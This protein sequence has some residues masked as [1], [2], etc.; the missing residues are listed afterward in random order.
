VSIPEALVAV[1]AAAGLALL[2]VMSRSRKALMA[3]PPPP[4]PEKLPPIT[5]LKPLKG[6]DS[7]L[8][9]NLRSI[10]RQ[11][12]PRFEVILGTEDE[13]DPALEV[14]RRVAEEYPEIPSRVVS[15]PRAVGYNPKVNNLANLARRANH[16]T[17]LISDS[18]V[19][20]DSGYLG[21]LVAHRE[22]AG[23]GLVWSLF[24]GGS[25]GGLGGLLE[26]I[27]LNSF[28]M[29]GVAAIHRVLHL[30]CC[31]GKSMLMGRAELE[32]VGGFEFLSRFLAEDQVCAEEFAARGI[33]VTVSGRL[34]E[35]VLGRRTLKE[36]ASRHLRWSRLR[37]HV[38]FV[39]YVGELLLNPV[40]VV[41][42]AALVLRTPVAVALAG[43]TLAVAS[44]LDVETERSM[45]IRRSP[46]VYPLLELALS[47]IK[48]FLWAIPLFSRTLTWRSNI[49]RIGRRSEIVLKSRPDARLFDTRGRRLPA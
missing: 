39:G 10:F 48:G 24:R 45:G 2:L 35:N 38:N 40:F 3:S 11:D 23:G 31:V 18:N 13:D 9:E 6:V 16:P 29:G 30:P 41:V 47:L 44:I 22:R 42:L 36:F 20:V 32:A 17:L 37:R 27:Q 43:A 49:L 25:E 34:I 26:A 5:I 14:A 15:D 19:R 1:M 7:A 21:D 4:E 8:E 46:A 12:Y 33:P 28:V